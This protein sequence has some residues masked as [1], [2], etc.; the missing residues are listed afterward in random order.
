MEQY[1]LDLEKY[2]TIARQVAAESCVLLKN[3]N[4]ALPLRQGD[5]VAVFGRCAFNYYKKWS[6]FRGLSKYKVCS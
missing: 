5:K 4:K 6:R 1:K 2:A 3:D